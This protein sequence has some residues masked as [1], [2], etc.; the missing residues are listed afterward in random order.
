[1]PDEHPRRG[2]LVYQLG[3]TTNIVSWRQPLQGPNATARCQVLCQDGRCLCSAALATVLD[4]KYL[5]TG[6]LCKYCHPS[7]IVPA[8]IG[9]R[10]LWILR[11]GL[12]LAVLDQIESHTPNPP[13]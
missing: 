13:F 2:F 11:L 3:N 12:G 8:P 5:D 6:T 4:L 7:Y 1:M 10:S 9:K